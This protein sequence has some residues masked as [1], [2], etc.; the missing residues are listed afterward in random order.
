MAQGLGAEVRTSRPTTWTQCRQRGGAVIRGSLVMLDLAGS[1]SLTA[2]WDGVSASKLGTQAAASGPLGTVLEATEGLTIGRVGVLMSPTVKD[3]GLG[4]YELGEVGGGLVAPVVVENALV[5]VDAASVAGAAL[6]VGASGGTAVFA[7]GVAGATYG[8]LLEDCTADDGKGPSASYNYRAVLLYSQ[9]TGSANATLAA[10]SVGEDE[11]EAGAVADALARDG[12]LTRDAFADAAGMPGITRAALFE[13]GIAGSMQRCSFSFDPTN[14]TD[15]T[16]RFKRRGVSRPAASAEYRWCGLVAADRPGIA[17]KNVAGVYTLEMRENATALAAYVWT[18]DLE[19]HE[20]TLAYLSTGTTISIDGVAV[21][22]GVAASLLDTSF[23]FAIGATTTAATV[24]NGDHATYRD[25]EVIDPATATNKVFLRL[26]EPS[27]GPYYNAYLRLGD[28]LYDAT[29][30]SAVTIATT[31]TDTSR[32]K[33][34]RVNS[35]DGGAG[36]VQESDRTR[37]MRVA[38]FSGLGDHATAGQFGLV[39][40]A[41]TGTPAFNVEFDCAR[42]LTQGTALVLWGRVASSYANIN[43]TAAGDLQARVNTINIC[44]TSIAAVPPDGRNRRAR[45]E[46]RDSGADVTAAIYIGGRLAASGTLAATQFSAVA[47]DHYVGGNTGARRWSGSIFNVLVEDLN[48]AANSGFWL[49]DE[50]RGSTT[51]ANTYPGTSL[52]GLT[53]NGFVSSCGV[54]SEDG[55]GRPW[56][57]GDGGA[58]RY[59]A[60]LLADAAGI[61]GVTPQTITGLTEDERDPTGHYAAGVFT[62]PCAGVAVFNCNASIAATTLAGADDITLGVTATSGDVYSSKATLTAANVYVPMA[63]SGI[64]VLAAGDTLTAAFASLPL[65]DIYTI[66]AGAAFHIDF[67]PTPVAG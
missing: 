41:P 58:F 48:S 26:D 36:V 25:F 67:T 60:R 46:F 65:A 23:T 21:A 61:T 27:G 34:A 28:P 2:D 53:I 49:M 33:S 54:E 7:A 14:T 39:S 4:E 10:G 17:F 40:W 50:P 19:E 9:G 45:V 20:W 66:A 29:N 1:D 32:P 64:A 8:I 38:A 62:A 31:G 42:S 56:Q 57:P 63:A 16:I 47:A 22:T 18:D 37:R 11:L 3:D 15:L 52:A 35:V 24:F 55:K 59:G 44:T 12:D 13:P 5:L 51:Y 6:Q 43:I 30:T